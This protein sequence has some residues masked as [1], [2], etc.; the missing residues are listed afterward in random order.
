MSTV[1]P[2]YHTDRP[3]KLT[4]PEVISLS[5]D[6]VGAHQNFNGS[7]DLIT[8]LSGMVKDFKYGR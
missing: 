4:A 6:M 3:P 1:S 7:R 2:V 8:P 5:R